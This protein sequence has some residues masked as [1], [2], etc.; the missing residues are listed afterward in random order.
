MQK[1]HAKIIKI[2]ATRGK[3]YKIEYVTTEENKPNYIIPEILKLPSHK[4]Q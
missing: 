3:I 2:K 1:K 4:L